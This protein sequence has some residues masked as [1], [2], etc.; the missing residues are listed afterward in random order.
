MKKTITLC[1]IACAFTSSNNAFGMLPKETTSNQNEPIV[2]QDN[3][4]DKIES[5]RLQEKNNMLLQEN[6]RLLR[7]I[8]TQNHLI[9][10]TQRPAD[11]FLY[12][13]RAGY[14]K[15]LND[16]YEEFKLDNNS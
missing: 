12:T 1:L 7:T 10:L 14:Y 4:F 3:K 9:S 16:I 5:Q 15:K 11:Y 8:I 13:P 2:S 6:N